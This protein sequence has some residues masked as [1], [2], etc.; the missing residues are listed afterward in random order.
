MV[1]NQDA[2]H[3]MRGKEKRKCD[4]CGKEE[5]RYRVKWFDSQEQYGIDLCGSCS[6]GKSKEKREETCLQLY[7]VKYPLQSKEIKKK[8]EITTKEKY[9]VTSLFSLPEVQDSIR[10]NREK[11]YGVRNPNQR[12][13]V[14]EKAKKTNLEKYGVENV[15]SSPE[16][17]EKTK[18]TLLKKYNVENVSQSKEVMEK[19]QKTCLSKYGSISSL[20]NAEIREKGKETIKKRYGVDHPMK[21]RS[22]REKVNNTMTKNGKVPTSSQ[23]LK[24]YEE[25]EKYFSDWKVSLNTPLSSLALD[26]TLSKKDIK[27]DIEYD[28]GYWHQD[29]QKDRKRDEFVKKQ[30]YKVL[31]IK[32]RRKIPTIQQIAEA[33]NYLSE[34]NE[35]TFSQ[36]ILPDWED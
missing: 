11:K 3:A 23:Q 4:L 29:S 15:F 8:S 22:I 32:S 24:I 12:K 20:G 7:G 33:I 9:G 21:N 6:K 25:C 36:I 30:G 19:T 28:G 14:Q 1:K 10:D 2:P 17:Q 34:S 31:R 18:K 35:H 5:Y 27:I 26:I 13:E 16:I